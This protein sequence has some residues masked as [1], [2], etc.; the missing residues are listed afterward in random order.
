MSTDS[1]ETTT[2]PLSLTERV[3]ALEAARE[4]SRRGR[5]ALWVSAISVVGGSFGVLG[6]AYTMYTAH[7]QVLAAQEQIE[8]SRQQ[9]SIGAE[10]LEAAR[11]ETRAQ[12]L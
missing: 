3:A 5:L 7:E 1:K 4:D 12:R 2:W 6:G 10:Q 11:A 8:L 9:T